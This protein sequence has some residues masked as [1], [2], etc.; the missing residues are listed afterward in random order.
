MHSTDVKTLVQTGQTVVQ[1]ISNSHKSRLQFQEAFTFP[2]TFLY[3]LDKLP[4]T[5]SYDDIAKALRMQL[6]RV[7]FIATVFSEPC[8]QLGRRR[9]RRLS[10]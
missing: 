5:P 2:L 9:L 10:D 1:C 3:F 6:Y 8:G 7:R 4:A